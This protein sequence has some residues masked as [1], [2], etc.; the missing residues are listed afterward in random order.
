MSAP[1]LR[2]EEAVSVLRTVATLAGYHRDI[3]IGDGLV[4]DVARLSAT[5]LFVGDAKASETSGC[6]ATNL[7]LQAY[8]RA[9]DAHRLSG[10]RL[11]VMIAH[12]DLD[13]QHGW[14]A[15]L[16]KAL[17]GAGLQS[18]RASESVVLDDE[19]VLAYALVGV[20]GR[21]FV[22]RVGDHRGRFAWPG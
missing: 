3:S 4:P 21:G 17:F 9:G 7:R 11:L 15:A 2:H 20:P 13:D 18:P 12:G 10:G 14:A 1:S 6:A 19:C 5:G 22:R 8:F 16:R